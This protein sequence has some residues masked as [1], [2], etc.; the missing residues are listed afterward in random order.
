MPDAPAALAHAEEAERL[1]REA[2]DTRGLV[3]AL[4]SRAQV[5]FA[6]GDLEAV[7]RCAT[8]ALDTCERHGDRWLRAGPL[9]TLGWAALLDG[10]PERARAWLEEALPLYRELGDLGGIVL[11]TLVPLSSAALRQKDVEAAESYASEAVELSRDTGWEA[12]ALVCYGEALSELGD[13]VTAG[14]A[15]SRALRIALESGLEPWFRI[16][17]RSLMR[18][19]AAGG[20]WEDAAVLLGA[21]RRDIS[22]HLHDPAVHGPIEERCRN[23]LGRARFDRLVER[24]QAMDHDRLM[25]LAGADDRDPSSA[26]TRS[27]AT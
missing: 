21:C 4:W 25:R 1:A 26:E 3:V 8:E 27:P 17:L 7:R 16:A 11:L 6:L 9:T 2:A 18:T 12:P 5:G 15:A 20:R 10:S 24:G 14:G 23:A 13:P 19:A 22:V